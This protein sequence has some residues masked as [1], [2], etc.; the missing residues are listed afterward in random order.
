MRAPRTTAVLLIAMA[1]LVIGCTMTQVPTSEEAR[2]AKQHNPTEE[3]R[4]VLADL[5]AAW[6]AGD[7]GRAVAVYSDDYV[8]PSGADKSGVRAYFEGLAAQGGFQNTAVGIKECK[9]VV[10]GDSANAGPVTFDSATGRESRSF[11]FGKEADGVWRIVHEGPWGSLFPA[12]NWG[13]HESFSVVMV[14]AARILGIQTD[15][16]TVQAI[17][18]NAFAPTIDPHEPSGHCWTWSNGVKL[19][20]AAE[21]ET[22]CQ[23]I[24]MN[25]T[26]LKRTDDIEYQIGDFMVEAASI[27]REALSDES[28]VISPGEWASP[29]PH[30]PVGWSRWGIVTEA[31]ED[32]TILGALL[33]GHNDN[34]IQKTCYGG[35]AWA[36]QP[37]PATIQPEELL[38]RT[39]TSALHRIRGDAEPFMRTDRH[40]SGLDA[41]EVWIK[42]MRTIPFNPQ[43]A[44][45]E[46][47][48]SSIH[49]AINTAW[50]T[51][52]GARIVS[53][54]LRNYPSDPQVREMLSDVAECYEKIRELLHPA[55][56]GEGGETYD[57][58]MD[59]LSKQEAHADQVLQPVAAE[60][61]KAA[62]AIE[63]I[64]AK[65]EEG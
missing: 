23:A 11:G 28:V 1:A 17:S 26:P 51:Y 30:G 65:L 45:P 5:Q 38:A 52:D 57:Q 43:S 20:K 32:G 14:T 31:G 9:I 34:P 42:R 50:P 15:Y 22:V 55:L 21:L 19:Q 47:G 10:D 58:F 24:G 13:R 60:L 53:A 37:A 48:E 59:D 44:D 33:N 27:V 6:Q 8:H 12:G 63:T 62:Q 36:L 49:A 3:V 61:A 46:S 41:M 35:E 29:G 54:Y 4:A 25:V 7:A 2:M 64:L 56:T 18:G 40:S 39:L 16:D